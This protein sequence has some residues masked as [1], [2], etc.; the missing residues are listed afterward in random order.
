MKVHEEYPFSYSL[1][2]DKHIPTA[3]PRE[4][5]TEPA[6]YTKN[7]DS[8][9]TMVCIDTSTCVKNY[10]PGFPCQEYHRLRTLRNSRLPMMFRWQF[11]FYK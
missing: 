6:T 3:S 4:T 8:T 2:I 7:N 10:I 9:N 11:G 5:T 1:R